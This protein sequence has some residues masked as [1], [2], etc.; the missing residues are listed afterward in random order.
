MDLGT[1]NVK[2]NKPGGGGGGLLL[3]LQPGVSSAVNPDRPR[4]APVCS[5]ELLRPAA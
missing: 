5:R 1:G 4:S 3:S 2:M